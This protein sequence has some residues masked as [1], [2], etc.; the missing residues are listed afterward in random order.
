MANTRGDEAQPFLDKLA[1]ISGGAL[2]L[3]ADPR[4]VHAIPSTETDALRAVKSGEVDVAFV[5][6]RA[7]PFVG[8]RSFDALMDPMLI[9]N[10]DLQ[11][12]VLGDSMIGEML[13]AVG[14]AGFV[15]VGVLPGPI[16]L[17]AGISRQLLGPASY[18]GALIGYNPSPVVQRS[19]QALGARP[20]EA[21]FSGDDITSFDGIELQ[22]SAVSTNEYDGVVTSITANV[23]LWP[24]PIAIVA[25][26]ASWARLSDAQRSW[27]MQ[28]AKDSVADTAA[29]QS[30]P[31]A[32]AT[33]CRRGAATII[34]ASDDQVAELRRAFAPVDSWLRTDGDTASYLDRIQAIKARQGTASSGQ[35]IDCAALTKQ[36]TPSDSS[37]TAS[38]TLPATALDGNYTMS[39]TD[40]DLVAVGASAEDVLAENWGEF[41]L[42]LDH[43]RFASTQYNA[44]ACTWNYG[45]YLATDTSIELSMSGGGGK[46]PNGA[47]NEPGELFDY[48]VSTYRDTMTW[49]IPPG[50]T[51]PFGFTLKPWQRIGEPSADYLDQR[52][53]PPAS[54]HN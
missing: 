53:A 47:T 13:D 33:M 7:Y 40:L 28:A 38:P 29:L 19:L 11:Q 45:T 2:Q 36:P 35:P 9:D 26:S 5:P 18:A 23:G 27:L 43:G 54:W 51:A 42:V 31:E 22:A 25:G 44:Q 4:F 1:E 41:R 6:T 49:S 46:A 34:A 50:A 15:G 8:V 52:C 21:A 14:S 39:Y 20:V 48:T 32:I 3:A 10:M 16:R 37:S 17:P 24:R 12:Q 30:D